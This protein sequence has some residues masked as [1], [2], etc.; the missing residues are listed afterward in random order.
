MRQLAIELAVNQ[1]T[2]LRVYERLE[3]EGLIEGRRG[4]G[5]F[6][7]DR[8]GAGARAGLQAELG[9]LRAEAEALARR[10]RALGLSGKAFGEM[11]R[12]AYAAEGEE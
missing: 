11:A 12:E 8:T 7:A 2:I 10:A 9:R 4:S 5:T 3:A 6:V 1:N